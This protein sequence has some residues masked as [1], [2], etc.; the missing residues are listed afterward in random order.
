MAYQDLGLSGST[1]RTSKC[2]MLFSG[3]SRQ[4]NTCTKFRVTLNAILRRFE[5]EQAR[6][7]RTSSSS[8]T[9]FR[10]L[11]T[12]EKYSRLTEMRDSLKNSQ[13][14]VQRL[15]SRL[16][17]RVR[18]RSAEVDDEMHCDLLAIMRDNQVNVLEKY[19]SGQCFY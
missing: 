1:I 3:S 13:K 17:E 8:R 2:A 11:N 15:R 16:E 4:C 6:S 12:P 14:Q 19:P 10:F 5:R 18:D 9:N 7:D